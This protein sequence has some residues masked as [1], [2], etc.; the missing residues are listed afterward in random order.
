[1]N[2]L[3]VAESS[4]TADRHDR[5]P[6][7]RAPGRARCRRPRPGPRGRR[8]ASPEPRRRRALDEPGG[9]SASPPRRATSP[10]TAA[11]P[12]VVAGDTLAAPAHALVARDQRRAR[13]TSARRCSTASRSRS[14]RSTTSHRCAE[15]V[16]DMQR[17]PGRAAA[18]LGRQPGLRRAGRPR[19]RRARFQAK[20]ALRVHHGLYD[21]E[22]AR[23]TAT[24]TCPRRTTSRAGATRAPTTA[25][26]RIVQ[27]LIEP[28][29]GGKTADRDA[30]RCSADAPTRRLRPAARQL[31][32]AAGGEPRRSARRLHDGFVADSA[33]P[34]L[35]RRHRDAGAARA[36]VAAARGRRARSPQPRRRQPGGELELALRPDPSVLDGRFANN[37]WLQELP[38]PITKLTWDNAL[39]LSPRDRRAARRAPTRRS[40]RSTA[41]GRKLDGAGLDPARPGRRRRARCTSATAA[42]APARSPTASAS[43]PTPLQTVG[44][45]LGARGASRSGRPASA[46]PLASTQD[47]HAIDW[48]RDETEQ[49]DAHAPS[50]ARRRSTSSR[51]TRTSSTARARRA[52]HQRLLRPRRSS[53]RA[54]PGA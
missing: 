21:D 53:T 28:L 31:G 46:Q 43:T 26:S 18:R 22:T 45:P 17:R 36:A 16:D 23:A 14:I 47:H 40:S 20:A 7:P 15:L 51:R 11:A 9:R 8:S 41:G 13:R 12:L 32:S 10:P 42:R 5:R 35:G 6:P 49:A 38:K 30:R 52:R 44:R 3:Y 25:R 33:P 27:P 39:L 2:R 1:M 54:T 24:G 48:M 37:G 34:A 50:C 29:Y 19:V 4:P